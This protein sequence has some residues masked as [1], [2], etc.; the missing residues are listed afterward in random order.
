MDPES[1]VAELADYLREAVLD[2]EIGGGWPTC[3]DHGTHPL[4]A[5][6]DDAGVAIWYCPR[7]TTVAR[8]GTLT[9][10]G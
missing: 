4:E 10:I 1:F 2:E 7:G 8:I 6:T 9:V 5:G 3:P